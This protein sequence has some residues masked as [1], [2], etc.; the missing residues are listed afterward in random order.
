MNQALIGVMN[1]TGKSEALV[2]I[3]ATIDPSLWSS[4]KKKLILDALAF[5]VAS[6]GRE[7]GRMVEELVEHCC[8]D[9]LPNVNT[10]WRGGVA[11]NH[12]KPEK[13]ADFIA[14]TCA[15]LRLKK[16]TER[17]VKNPHGYDSTTGGL[18]YQERMFLKR[19]ERHG[20][21]PDG[22]A[23]GLSTWEL[24]NGGQHIPLNPSMSHAEKG[25]FIREYIVEPND[26]Q[27]EKRAELARQIENNEIIT[28]TYNN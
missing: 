17:V 5:G 28:F 7:T 13:Y 19:G 1:I 6:C 10:G 25:R 12:I 15:W 22:L 26:R 27:V 14:Y 16:A 24:R 18:N 3:T 4:R 20:F 9:T 8:G 23:Q 21:S 11:V 2:K